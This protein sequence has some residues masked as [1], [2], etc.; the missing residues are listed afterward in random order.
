M[1]PESRLCPPTLPPLVE[2]ASE[3]CEWCGSAVATPVLVDG[4]A[5]CTR[6]CADAWQGGYV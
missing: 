1:P 4:L 5:F 3:I 6:L 2:I